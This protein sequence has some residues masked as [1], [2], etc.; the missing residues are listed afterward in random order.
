MGDNESSLIFLIK[1]LKNSVRIFV[2]LVMVLFMGF[3]LA[4]LKEY[5]HK[6]GDEFRRTLI[7][8]FESTKMVKIRLGE[9]K[10]DAKSGLSKI[11]LQKN[12]TKM[13]IMISVAFIIDQIF[14]IFVDRLYFLYDRTNCMLNKTVH[15]V[16]ELFSCFFHSINIIVYNRM[17]HSSN[18]K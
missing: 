11:H 13:I 6:F 3:L 10:T 17:I 18:N 4:Q 14:A 15:F 2:S 5:G 12:I 9:R 8:Y 16:Y 1:V 7:A